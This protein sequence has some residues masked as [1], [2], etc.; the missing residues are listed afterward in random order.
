MLYN[1]I[2]Y[3]EDVEVMGGKIRHFML[4][5][6]RILQYHIFGSLLTASPDIKSFL[7]LNDVSSFVFCKESCFCDMLPP[8]IYTTYL[9]L[10]FVWGYWTTSARFNEFGWAG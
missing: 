4:E 8:V 9:F 5:K 3:N 2:H 6:G 10:A 1:Q 7:K